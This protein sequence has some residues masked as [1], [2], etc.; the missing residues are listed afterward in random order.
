MRSI[1]FLG[2]LARDKPV[3]KKINVTRKDIIQTGS[4]FVVTYLLAS[5]TD[6]FESLYYLTREYEHWNLDEI[7]L[8]VLVSPLPLAWFAF[9]KMKQ[10]TK[11]IESRLEYEEAL[12][13]TSKMQSL[14]VLA[15]G[16]AH[17]INNQLLPI[18]TMAELLHGRLDKTE[19]DHR[20]VEL[21][22]KAAQRAQETVAKILL[23]SRKDLEIKGRGELSMIWGSL[24]QLLPALCPAN[25]K[26][27]FDVS[28]SRG[29]VPV[30]ET[31]IQG[32]IVNLFSNAIDAMGTSPG[33]ITV[34][35]V[36]GLEG[37]EQSCPKLG[38]GSYVR[39]SV[40]D[41]GPGIEPKVQQKIFD[42]FF[43]T[44]GPGEG[45]GLGLSIV[46]ATVKQAKGEIV[47]SSE[48]GKG[49][50]FDIYLPLD[51]ESG[52]IIGDDGHGLKGDDL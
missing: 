45:V 7:L 38:A 46:Y 29:L 10:T 31:D 26:L 25:V 9:S 39:I 36:A 12:A 42:P 22:L 4:L 18:L 14:G 1:L 40:H 5:F 50:C 49:T 52:E 21:I 8:L 11:E 44:K 41:T 28:D 6:A 33:V 51:V 23:F 30:S 17:E 34:K 48:P 13:E 16:V 27:I 24:E 35:A 47:L 2:L 37:D 15:G 19:P 3:L 32:I 20:K 43:T